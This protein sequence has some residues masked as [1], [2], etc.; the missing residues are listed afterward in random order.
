MPISREMFGTGLGFPPL[1]DQGLPLVSGSGA[2]AQSLRTLLFTEP[3]ERIGRPG[4]GCGLRRF[5]FAP[6]T[7]GTR[8]LIQQTITEAIAAHEPRVE[9][10]DVLV[11]ADPRDSY[12][13]RIDVRYRLVGELTPENLVFPFYLNNRGD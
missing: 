1:P 5:L 8:A 12:T 3:G 13:L 10:D 7:V 2:V 11:R 4:Y 9:L 6:N